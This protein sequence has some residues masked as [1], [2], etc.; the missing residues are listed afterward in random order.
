M[1][2]KLTDLIRL[3]L[4]I[5]KEACAPQRRQKFNGKCSCGKERLN[6]LCTVFVFGQAVKIVQSL[7]C[8]D[9]AEVKLNAWSTICNTCGTPIL[10]GQPVASDP[11]ASGFTHYTSSCAAFAELYAGQ[12]GQDWKSV[13]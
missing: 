5:I 2:R 11:F 12:W 10:P 4:V 3:Y 7:Y 13:V 9:C 8:R 6:R 1:M